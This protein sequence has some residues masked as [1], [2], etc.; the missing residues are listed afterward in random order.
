MIFALAVT[1]AGILFPG[2]F[3]NAK[4]T[5]AETKDEGKAAAKSES[6]KNNHAKDHPRRYYA[7][8]A[9]NLGASANQIE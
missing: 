2:T 3:A 8:A 4:E 7:A 9:T 5:P 6:G 1:L